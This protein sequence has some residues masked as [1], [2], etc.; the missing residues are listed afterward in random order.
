[1]ALSFAGLDSGD[2]RRRAI[3]STRWK[4]AKCYVVFSIQLLGPMRYMLH[5]KFF[6][7]LI[8][9]CGFS[10]ISFF[11]RHHTATGEW[12]QWP[13]WHD[14]IKERSHWFNAT[15]EKMGK[16]RTRKDP[17]PPSENPPWPTAMNRFL[18]T[19]GFP[20]VQVPCPAIQ[21]TFP[22]MTLTSTIE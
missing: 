16:T 10:N 17:R 4:S 9:G 22:F 18:K 13:F 3:E 6:Y 8:V 1:M 20:F 15:F 12:L 14:R 2:A 19:N 21:S 5:T 7:G 11:C